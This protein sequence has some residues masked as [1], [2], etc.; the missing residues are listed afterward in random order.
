MS[1]IKA[2]MKAARTDIPA[3]GD[4]DL[5]CDCQEWDGIWIFKMDVRVV[6]PRRAEA[7]VSFAVYEPKNRPKDNLRTYKYILI[8]EHGQ[9]RIYDVEYLSYSAKSDEPSSLREQIRRDIE[10]YAHQP[11][12]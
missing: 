10:Y 11:K 8:P 2:D 1:L 3:A 12:P 6:N 7:V 9:W 4:G 5:I